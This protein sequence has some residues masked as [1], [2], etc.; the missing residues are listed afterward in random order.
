VV[1][2]RPVRCKPISRKIISVFRNEVVRE[3]LSAIL[4]IAILYFGIQGTIFLILRTDSPMMAVVSNSMKPTFERGDLIFVKGVDSP[5]QIIQGDIIVFQFPDDPE[6]KVH[7]V[8]EIITQDNEVQFK[9]KGDNPITNP[10]PDSRLVKFE[11]VKGKVIFWVPK[12]GYISL[13]IRGE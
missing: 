6:T 8:V 10:I 7:R 3:A 1:R 9:T 5:D 12:L 11:E 2:R 13:W 4:I